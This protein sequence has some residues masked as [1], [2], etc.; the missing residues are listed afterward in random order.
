MSEISEL[1]T[2][3]SD[4]VARMNQDIQSTD[5]FMLTF[6]LNDSCF[7]LPFESIR[8]IVDYHSF[9]P[10]PQSVDGHLGVINF[11]G[12]IVP[13]IWPFS[14]PCMVPDAQHEQEYKYLVVELEDGQMLALYAHHLCKIEVSEDQ[15]KGADGYR[16]IRDNDRAIRCLEVET[17]VKMLKP[18]I[19]S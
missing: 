7:S 11:R 5:V 19:E 12:T 10:Y 3:Q 15:I 8:E 1:Y 18:K 13:V 4:L 17:F 9:V 16:I 6:E 2:E 14:S